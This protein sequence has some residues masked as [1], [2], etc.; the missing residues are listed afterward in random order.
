MPIKKIP[1][2]LNCEARAGQ[3]VLSVFTNSK[4]GHFSCNETKLYEA[5]VSCIHDNYGFF[6]V[7]LTTHPFIA[8]HITGNQDKMDTH[9]NK[10]RSQIINALKENHDIGN[11]RI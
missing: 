5:L 10:M 1:N 11:V 8:V 3:A 9:G 2:Q 4:K 7:H 6:Q